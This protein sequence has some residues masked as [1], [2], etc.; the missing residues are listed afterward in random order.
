MIYVET[1]IPVAFLSRA[2]CKRADRLATGI[3]LKKEKSP[4]CGLNTFTRG[5]LLA[6]KMASTGR[7]PDLEILNY[8]F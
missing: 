5:A 1:M 3:F 6:A 2:P 4:A 8:E 7:S